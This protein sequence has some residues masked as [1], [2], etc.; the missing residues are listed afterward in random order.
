[1]YFGDLRVPFLVK[2]PKWKIASLGQQTFPQ[3]NN[4]AGSIHDM[5]G[6][7]EN[8][9]DKDRRSVVTL[10]T[11]KL[12]PSLQKPNWM[13]RVEIELLSASPPVVGAQAINS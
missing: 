10:D 9:E 7:T 2:Q 6:M 1:M 13:G 11:I 4:G 3:V 5:L 8:T 12:P